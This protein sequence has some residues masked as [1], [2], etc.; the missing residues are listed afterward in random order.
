MSTS[1]DVL[2]IGAGPTG[3]GAAKRLNHLKKLSW[4][5]VDHQEN[6]GGLSCTQLTPEGFLYDMGV[7]VTFSHYKYYDDCLDEA[8][9]NEDDWFKHRRYSLIFVKDRWI[10]YPLQNNIC[11]LSQDDQVKCVD[12]LI[13]ARLNPVKSCLT[14]DDWILQK[15]GIGIADVFMRPYNEKIWTLPPREMQ[16]KWVGERVAE[17]DCKTIIKNII[18][19]IA[20]TGWGPTAV[21]RFSARGGTGQIWKS[22]AKTLP[23]ENQSYGSGYKVESI[24]AAEK[25]ATL[26]NGTTIKYKHLI[27]TMPLQ[28]LLKSMNN[29]DLLPLAES[30]FYTHT[31]V[32]CVGVRGET[33]ERAVNGT[34][35]YF[36]DSNSPFYRATIYSNFSPY[37]V[38]PKEHKL[39]T[40]QYASKSIEESPSKEPKEGPYW[41]MILEIAESSRKTV[42]TA[43]LLQDCLDG[44]LIANL[45]EPKSEIVT[46]HHKVCK[47]GY[48]VPT[49]NRDEILD[50]IL[51]KLK[52]QGIYSRGRFGSWKYEVANQDHS[53]MLGVEAIDSI[54]YGSP[55]LTLNYPDLINSRNNSE[56]RLE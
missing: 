43:T 26:S 46:L 9:P 12:G 4:H 36:P 24:N 14:F 32:V 22:V 6:A 2:I 21:F 18:Y 23:K 55:E 27:S 56:R 54:I 31:H 17:P 8:L 41:S 35:H 48:P 25:I 37:N 19:H 16:H 51:P 5:L 52:E 49:L 10:P 53:F 44:L 13:D 42:D 45:L 7:H 33:L 40:L 15:T 39:P 20:E 11:L 38:P 3:L 28:L 1:I 50:K 34:W 29:T 30:L 47:Y